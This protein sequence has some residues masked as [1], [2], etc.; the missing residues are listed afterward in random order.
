MKEK[1]QALK[2]LIQTKADIP[3]SIFISWLG[4]IVLAAAFL[5]L[6]DYIA[7]SYLSHHDSTIFEDSAMGLLHTKP[8]LD[9]VKE[10]PLFTK[11]TSISSNDTLKNN[12]DWSYSGL[13]GEKQW[14]SLGHGICE[15]GRAQSPIDINHIRSVA[16]GVPLE[17]QY[18]QASLL[19]E[20]NGRYL[21]SNIQG[22]H[23]LRYKN[24]MFQLEKI[25][26]HTPGE[27]TFEGKSYPLE[28]QFL[29]KD[30]QGNRLVL[31]LLGELGNSN[32]R[33]QP[34]IQNA[35][36]NV[37][38]NSGRHTIDIGRLLP[39]AKDY[40][41]YLGSMTTPPC[42]EGIQW[43]VLRSRTTFSPQQIKRL[44]DATGPNARS[45]QAPYS[46][47]IELHRLLAH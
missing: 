30:S 47:Q 39:Y 36:Q 28:I 13:G 24:R 27:H 5:Y 40:F 22:R 32:A 8:D 35:P 37:Q 20:H 6:Q 3:R 23:G 45:V 7:R 1:F 18:G 2:S 15:T 17:F 25:A 14:A 10:E 16:Y 9:K 43:I 44:E 46:R 41:A 21:F 11:K 12:L 31:S 33:L 38:Q 34:I 26:I 29:H 42:E 19:L 4:A